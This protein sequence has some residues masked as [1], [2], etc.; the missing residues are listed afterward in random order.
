MS[1]L[2]ELVLI[3]REPRIGA[4]LYGV[5]VFSIWAGNLKPERLRETM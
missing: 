1:M 5:G 3:S 2:R 4:E